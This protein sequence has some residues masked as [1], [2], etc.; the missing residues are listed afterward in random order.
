VFALQKVRYRGLAKNLP[1]LVVTAALAKLFMVR[2]QLLRL[3]G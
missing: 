2:R 3:Q 1:Q